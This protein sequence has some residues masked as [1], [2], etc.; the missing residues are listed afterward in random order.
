[1][2]QESVVQKTSVVCEKRKFVDIGPSEQPLVWRHS[3]QDAFDNYVEGQRVISV[4]TVFGK[5]NK[6]FTVIPID[7]VEGL[8]AMTPKNLRNFY[9]MNVL[10]GLIEFPTK[11]YYDFDLQGQC[12]AEEERQDVLR[13]IR[14][15]TTSLFEKHF[16]VHLKQEDF[17]EMDSTSDIKTSLHVVINN[18]HFKNV[19]VLERLKNT[20]FKGIFD[21]LPALDK[22]V[23]TKNRH[24]R[25]LGCCKYGK[26]SFS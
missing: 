9:E 13:K 4:D 20:W 5:Q 14:T 23:Y 10:S 2:N 12:L 18:Y 3:Q 17:V 8:I 24:F 26:N 21:D 1:M 19:Q 7:D 11:M 6:R 25:L 22:G 15:E 16:D